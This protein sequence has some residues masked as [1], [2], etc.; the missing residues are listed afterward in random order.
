MTSWRIFHLWTELRLWLKWRRHGAVKPLHPHRLSLVKR[1][2]EEL[3][4]QA[5]YGRSK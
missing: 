2:Q 4:F 5:K 1:A 3:A